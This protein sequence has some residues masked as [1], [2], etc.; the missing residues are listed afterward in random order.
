LDLGDGRD[1][2]VLEEMR[3]L[4][5]L[6]WVSNNSSKVQGEQTDGRERYQ[7]G[8]GGQDTGPICF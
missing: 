4:T 8:E 2:G 3:V 7:E 6:A 1:T 5:L